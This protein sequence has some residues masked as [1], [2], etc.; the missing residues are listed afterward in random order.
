MGKYDDTVTYLLKTYFATGYIPDGD[1]FADVIEA[2]RDGIQEHEHSPDGGA[3]S[4][5]GDA[6]MATGTLLLPD[7]RVPIEEDEEIGEGDTGWVD[8]NLSEYLHGS[9]SRALLLIEA[10][11]TGAESTLSFRKKGMSSAM[12]SVK[13]N[14]NDYPRPFYVH[15]GVDS[16]RTLQRSVVVGEG[17]SLTMT[18]WII[19]REKFVAHTRQLFLPATGHTNGTPGGSASRPWIEFTDGKEQY[20]CVTM[21][22]PSDYLSL[23]KIEIVWYSPAPTGNMFWRPYATWS[24]KGEKIARWTKDAG[25]G[26]TP[27]AGANKINVQEPA[28]PF[29]P[30]PLGCGHYLGLSINRHAGR[31]QDTL[32]TYVRFLGFLF[33]YTSTG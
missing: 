21:R 18:T 20:T 28:T 11:A 25:Y 29:N 22:V 16:S 15:C 14:P 5:T 3:G 19:A 1:N 8:I 27:T 7:A 26:A 31:D 33:T 30:A 32:N 13:L 10:E 6:S 24:L 2:I 23:D 17:G 12:Y 9:A 4:G